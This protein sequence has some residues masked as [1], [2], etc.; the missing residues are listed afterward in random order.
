MDER[1]SGNGDGRSVTPEVAM[2]RYYNPLAV[3]FYIGVAILLSYSLF[4]V[5]GYRAIVIV[6]MIFLIDAINSTRFILRNSD[7]NIARRAAYFN[8]ILAIAAFV[9]LAVNG[10]TY[11][12]QGYYPILPHVENFTLAMPLLILST[13][14]GLRNIESMYVQ[15]TRSES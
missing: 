1:G 14:F 2:R 7:N 10:I 5:F 15:R 8:V 4:Y 11:E 3:Y 9:L 12:S 6:M 13:E